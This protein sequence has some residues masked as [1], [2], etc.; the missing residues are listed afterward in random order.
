VLDWLA[1]LN[2]T[3]TGEQDYGEADSFFIQAKK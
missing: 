3:M 1:K 2:L